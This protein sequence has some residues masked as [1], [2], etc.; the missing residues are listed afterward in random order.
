MFF[1]SLCLP[2]HIYIELWFLIIWVE[3]SPLFY[4]FRRILY[5]FNLIELILRE[6]FSGLEKTIAFVCCPVKP[7][8]PNDCFLRFLEIQLMVLR[9][10]YLD[11]DPVL[12]TTYLCLEHIRFRHVCQFMPACKWA[13]RIK[14]GDQLWFCIGSTYVLIIVIN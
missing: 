8:H 14:K 7:S 1:W 2:D 6:K 10:N 12:L 5:S 13:D 9:L 4:E 3:Q 11:P